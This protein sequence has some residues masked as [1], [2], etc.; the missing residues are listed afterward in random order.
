MEAETAESGPIA[1][2]ALTGKRIAMVIDQ[3]GYRDE[4]AVR[5]LEELALAGADVRVWSVLPDFW[6]DDPERVDRN[7]VRYARLARGSDGQVLHARTSM[8]AE[9]EQFLEGWAREEIVDWAPDVLAH[10]ADSTLKFGIELAEQLGRP[11]VSDLPDLPAERR[12]RGGRPYRRWER[13]R[14][15]PRQ[16]GDQL[17]RTFYGR[18]KARMTVAP[19]LASA[20]SNRYGVPRPSVL[21]NV[22]RWSLA[23]RPGDTVSDVRR[24]V[25]IDQ[26]VPLAAFVGNVKQGLNIETLLSALELLPGWHLALVGSAEWQLEKFNLDRQ[27]SSSTRRRIH[28]IDRQPDATLPDFLATADVGVFIPV[29]THFNLY[30]AAPNKFFAI[31]LAGVPIVVSESGFMS[32]SVRDHGLGQV[33]RKNKPEELARAL[34]DSLRERSAVAARRVTTVSLFGW[35]RQRETLLDTYSGALA[36]KLS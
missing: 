18:A 7:G 8:N 32:K 10:H 12:R 28:A 25:G 1:R 27:V 22:P 14:F 29:A 23:E 3:S 26:D 20:L 33:I 35:E 13:V 24:L 36:E 15:R 16:E 21:F 31:V 6:P 9:T 5:Q 19:G 30:H 11:I 17:L 34:S 4:R 2:T